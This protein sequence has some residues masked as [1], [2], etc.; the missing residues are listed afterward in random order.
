MISSVLRQEMV[1]ATLQ[2]GHLSVDLALGGEPTKK[3][4]IKIKIRQN[5]DFFFF[6][7]LSLHPVLRFYYQIKKVFRGKN[8][9]QLQKGVKIV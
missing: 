3:I 2:L 7:F 9:F 6:F 8:C 1:L 4:K 5:F